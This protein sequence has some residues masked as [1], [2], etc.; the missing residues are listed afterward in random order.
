[1][2]VNGWE[3]DG[4]ASEIS[5]TLP[6]RCDIYRRSGSDEWGGG[7]DFDTPH[8]M[9]VPVSLEPAELSPFVDKI[10]GSGREFGQLAQFELTF[11]RGT[12]VRD[13]DM[14]EV[15]TLNDVQIIVRMVEA[16]ES[17]DVSV[18]AQGTL[19]Q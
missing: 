15:T 14:I 2:Q 17:W 3:L 12:D 5:T 9:A 4:I 19:A 6:D 11:P 8:V 10:G 7:A 16:P 18:Q 13:G 1:M